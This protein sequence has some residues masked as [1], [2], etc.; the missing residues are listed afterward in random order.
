[1]YENRIV[2]LGRD[3]GDARRGEN[4]LGADRAVRMREGQAWAL[5]PG[6][7]L[8]LLNG[9]AYPGRRGCA[10]QFDRFGFVA[11]GRPFAIGDRQDA[12]IVPGI[13][14][15]L[16]P[17]RKYHPAEHE[18]GKDHGSAKEDDDPGAQAD[19]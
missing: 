13:V 8:H 4:R 12:E 11:S 19:V 7:A 6:A 1:M 10:P 14:Q 18:P 15:A 17:P 9:K 5:R 16:I 3:G 2:V